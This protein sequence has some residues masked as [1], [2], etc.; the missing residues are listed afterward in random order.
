MSESYIV[1]LF[2][3][4]CIL[5]SVWLFRIQE[6]ILFVTSRGEWRGKEDWDK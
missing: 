2:G 6:R 5:L 3:K 4:E 1:S